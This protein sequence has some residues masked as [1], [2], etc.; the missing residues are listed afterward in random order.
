MDLPRS[1]L[2]PDALASWRREET[3][4]AE[5]IA[6]VHGRFGLLHPGNLEVLLR[7]RE[8]AQNLLVVLSPDDD[9]PEHGEKMGERA[10]TVAH[11]RGVTASTSFAEP[12]PSV[13]Q[14]IRPYI[15]VASEDSDDD[16]S[17]VGVEDSAD[18]LVRVPVVPGCRTSQIRAAIADG[19]TPVSVP[20]DPPEGLYTPPRPEPGSVVTINGCFDVVHC[21]H[22]E[23][24]ARAAC[25][26][27]HLVVL[28]NDDASVRRYKGNSRP[29][30]PVAFR[31]RLLS[32]LKSVAAVGAFAEDEPLTALER[33][34]P[35]I[36]VKGGTFKENLVAHERALVGTW[37]GRIEYVSMIGDYSSTEAIRRETRRAERQ[38]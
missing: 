26:G 20:F 23:F 36:H 30:F 38:K 11:L 4:P 33:L 13:L 22:L 16:A 15:L 8:H 19:P 35:D 32:S 21:G 17:L 31:H 10:V 14:A 12:D 2:A 6:V 28:I 18:A 27:D 25:L 29:V 37:G 5:P 7:A 1:F 9:N 34:R 24:L 3:D